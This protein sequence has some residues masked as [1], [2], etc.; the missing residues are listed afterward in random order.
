MQIVVSQAHLV[1]C[2]SGNYSKVLNTQLTRVKEVLVLGYPEEFIEIHRKPL[3][4]RSFLCSNLNRTVENEI[5][6]Q[7]PQGNIFAALM[8][9]CLLD[10]S[11]TLH[12][13]TRIKYKFIILILL[14]MLNCTQHK[15]HLETEKAAGEGSRAA[16][17][18]C[19]GVARHTHT[20]TLTH[21]C[22]HYTITITGSCACHTI[23]IVFVVTPPLSV[24]VCVVLI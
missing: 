19:P 13:H 20:H 4:K 5:H 18:C 3:A 23:F 21:T 15:S 12:T 6:C 22:A 2:E 14:K 8:S 17:A 11:N 16:S 9:W 24:C 7:L 10:Y 1:H